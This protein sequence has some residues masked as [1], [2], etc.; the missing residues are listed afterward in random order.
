MGRE[1]GAR[2][3]TSSI[4]K[5]TANSTNDHFQH[6]T[7]FKPGSGAVA[8]Y[9]CYLAGNQSRWARAMHNNKHVTRTYAGATIQSATVF[10][11]MRPA[12]I[13]KHSITQL[14][15]EQRSNRKPGTKECLPIQQTHTQHSLAI[16]A[17]ATTAHGPVQRTGHAAV[18]Q[19]L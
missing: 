11:C 13:V 12:A 19:C 3:I 1:M 8:K 10:S 16:I 6:E 4:T 18:M 9:K 7:V 14:C 2:N 5:G 17:I 15:G